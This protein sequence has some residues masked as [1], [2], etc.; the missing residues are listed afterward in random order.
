MPDENRN[1]P[2]GVA[3]NVVDSLRG[4]PMVIGLLALNT[5]FIASFVYIDIQSKANY[6][7]LTA[8]LL[9]D[10][11]TPLRNPQPH[12]APPQQYQQPQSQSAPQN[13]APIPLPS[14]SRKVDF[15]DT[16]SVDK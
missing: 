1:N 8:E 7:F 13:L 15:K 5:A 4:N 16:T 12:Y 2:T 9:R 6:R 3:N 10:C 11:L 14:L